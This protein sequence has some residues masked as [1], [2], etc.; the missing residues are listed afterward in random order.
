MFENFKRLIIKGGCFEN[1][2]EL[3]LFKKDKLT[4]V[5]GRNGSG[6]TTIAHC[7]A[8]L[9]KPDE[10]KSADYTVKADAPIA[11]DMKES[12]L[13][14]DEDFV[15]DQVRVEGEGINTIVMLGEQVELDEKISKEKENFGKVDK[16]WNDLKALQDQYEDTEMS[17][18]P[19]YYFNKIRDGLREE[20]G[21][22]DIDRDLK[23]NTLKSRVTGDVIEN[24]LNIA[25]PKATYEELREM[26]MADLNLYLE[27][28]NAEVIDWKIEERHLPGDL[29][30]LKD[31]LEKKVDAPRLTEREQR[32]INIIAEHPQH[33]TQETKQLVAEGW[34]YCPLCLREITVE[35]AE[36]IKNTLTR[37]LNEEA[38]KYGKLLD[39]EID[40]FREVSQLLP[41][42]PGELHKDEINAAQVVQEN[43]NR[44]LD[45]VRRKIEERKRRIYDEMPRAI[46]EEMLDMYRECITEWRKAMT[47]LEKQVKSFNSTVSERR[48]LYD[49]IRNSNNI[50]AR[51]QLNALLLGYKQAVANSDSNKKYLENKRKERE[52]SEQKIK[53]LVQQKERTDIALDYINKELRYV[54][55]SNRKVKLE[56]GE[57][58]YKLKVNGRNVRPNKISVGE[59]NVLGLCYFFAKLYSGKTEAG[60]Y[61]SESLIVIDDPVSSFDYGNRVGV[62]SLLRFQF[63]NILKGNDKSRILVMSHDLHSVFDLVKIRNEV[64][65][66]RKPDQAFMELHNNK[67]EVKYMQNEYKKLLE[68][69]YAYAANTG[70]DDPDETQ[71][72]SIG[73]VM[74]RMMEAFSSFCYNETFERMVR[75]PE[76]LAIIPD[77]KRGYYE[78]FMGRLTLNTESHMAES[79]YTLD[80]ITT[81]FTKDEKLQTAK[82]VLLFLLYVNRPHLVAYL[83]AAQLATIENWK[84]EEA[85]WLV[86]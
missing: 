58:C 84:T 61:A 63:G 1:E 8:E 72:M 52:D 66:G 60:R 40:R 49:R 30:E 31:L 38:E 33:S 86:E 83:D 34:E 42:F 4:V 26:L 64:V 51:K 2:A 68:Y 54:F 22:A 14:F 41:V 6:K 48:K 80:T 78:N 19:G 9:T 57:G 56:P 17:F 82:S 23:G 53:Q 69:V 15:R 46:T 24:L 10:E 67:L 27:S 13:I 29:Q 77:G 5:Y 74:R 35:D 12:V 39:V 7:I 81:C 20:G 62:M 85:G 16:E 59:R 70:A 11:D 18:S 50:L 36:R 73:N 75:N 71:E 3:E 44:V 32:L 28:E 55:Y 47:K 25:E 79:V 45:L 43:L 37:I 21:W 65:A 76:V